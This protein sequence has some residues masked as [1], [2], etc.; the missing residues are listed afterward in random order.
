MTKFWCFL[1]H[2]SQTIKFTVTT[3]RS[4]SQMEAVS[5]WFNY[6][7]WCC[8]DWTVIFFSIQLISCIHS[9]LNDTQ[10]TH[11]RHTHCLRHTHMRRCA[12]FH[13]IKIHIINNYH[14]YHNFDSKMCTTHDNIWWARKIT[15]QFCFFLCFVRWWLDLR[16]CSWIILNIL[17][18]IGPFSI[19]RAFI[20]SSNGP[21]CISLVQTKKKDTN[22]NNNHHCHHQ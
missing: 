3:Q 8:D 18:E 2:H 6:C 17:V 16:E 21:F 7:K 12:Y 4:W 9:T 20:G 19:K 1:P 14:H 15:Q 5:K 10:G 13:V 22:N 11:K